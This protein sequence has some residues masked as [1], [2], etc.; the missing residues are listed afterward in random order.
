[1]SGRSLGPVM[2]H[3]LYC[4]APRIC[5]L[6]LQTALPVFGTFPAPLATFVEVRSRL[7][8]AGFFDCFC[9]VFFFAMVCSTSNLRHDLSSPKVRCRVQPLSQHRTYTWSPSSVVRFCDT[10]LRFW[11]IR[12]EFMECSPFFGPSRLGQ[13]PFV[14]FRTGISHRAL[15]CNATGLRRTA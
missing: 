12:R 14:G 11:D 8:G 15:A 1:M 9:S 10:Y 2:G 5:P 4:P 6:G 3:A 7:F 13:F